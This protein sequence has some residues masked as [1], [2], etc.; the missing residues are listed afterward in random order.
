MAT[1]KLAA[2]KTA[3]VIKMATVAQ[4]DKKIDYTH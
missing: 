3:K 2:T 4:V 1:A